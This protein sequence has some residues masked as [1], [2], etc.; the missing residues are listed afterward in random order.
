M[1]A[2]AL[3]QELDQ[4]QLAGAA[5]TGALGTEPVPAVEAREQDGLAQLRRLGCRIAGR[6]ST[7]ERAGAADRSGIAV[8]RAAPV[9][10]GDRLGDVCDHHPGQ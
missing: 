2:V 3:A 9:R 4:R 7:L 5:E 1:V 10:V 6:L 8:E